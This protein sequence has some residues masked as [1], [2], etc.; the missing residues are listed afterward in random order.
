MNWTRAVFPH[1]PYALCHIFG[2]TARHM[3]PNPDE[4]DTLYSIR[5]G[6]LL[7][8]G[9][10]IIDAFDPKQYELSEQQLT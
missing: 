5:D 10:H 6:R 8:R 4:V 7:Q 3:R 1:E 2:L 9:Y